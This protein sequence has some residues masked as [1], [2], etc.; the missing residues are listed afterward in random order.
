MPGGL[1]A[2]ATTTSGL[3]FH[4]TDSNVGSGGGGSGGLV[5]LARHRHH[6]SDGSIPV[7][8]RDRRGLVADM[9]SAAAS[10]ID[11]CCSVPAPHHPSLFPSGLTIRNASNIHHHHPASDLVG[12]SV[13]P[14]S[15]FH[16]PAMS[17]HSLTVAPMRP[18]ASDDA[19][20]T[21]IQQQQRPFRCDYCGKAFKLRH[22]MKDHCRVH[23]GERPFPCQLCGKTFSRSTILKAH[24]K[25]HLPKAERFHPPPPV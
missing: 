19:D 11:R 2:V 10:L 22:H 17:Y 21:L 13:N 24:E 9:M 4:P 18:I 6:S 3:L 14:A 8:Q 12:G 20:P 15:T 1:S 5:P 7:F 23:T 16:L 25:T